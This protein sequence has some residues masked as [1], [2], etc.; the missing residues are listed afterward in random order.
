MAPV[1]EAEGARARGSRDPLAEELGVDDEVERLLREGEE[2]EDTWHLPQDATILR[3]AQSGP[4]KHARLG[5]GVV[6]R[7]RNDDAENPPKLA[8]AAL[9]QLLP[10]V[11][12][13]LESPAGLAF[14][15]R[16]EAA[17]TRKPLG[18]V[19]LAVALSIPVGLCFRR[20]D[21]LC[22]GRRSR[23]AL[24]ELGVVAGDRGH[25][26]V[27]GIELW[28]EIRG[29]QMMVPGLGNRRAAPGARGGP[30]GDPDGHYNR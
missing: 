12:A 11:G 3:W 20:R 5:V 26:K 2:L 25:E 29:C 9:P 10:D 22:H 8:V 24:L 15:Q 19:A 13:V 30:V 1:S 18:G 27:V 28:V 23:R 14:V 16:P 7:L 4:L 6:A 17:L 21:P